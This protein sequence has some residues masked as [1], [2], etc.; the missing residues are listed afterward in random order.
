MP[1]NLLP[2]QPTSPSHADTGDISDMDSLPFHNKNN[3]T[4]RID[5]I[6]HSPFSSPEIHF[7][8][9]TPQTLAEIKRTYAF[10]LLAATA[11]LVGKRPDQ[12]ATVT[13]KNNELVVTRGHNEQREWSATDDTIKIDF[14]DEKGFTGDRDHRYYILDVDDITS[15]SPF[16]ISSR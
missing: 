11:E 10:T 5:I 15:L 6:S 16:P 12:I 7:K 8:M 9:A 1:G 2:A 14:W 13:R 4:Q 3:Q